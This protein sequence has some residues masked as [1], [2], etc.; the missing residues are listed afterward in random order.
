[1]SIDCVNMYQICRINAGIKSREKASE[2]LG[3]GK[4]SLDDYEAGVT[5]PSDETVNKMAEVYSDSKL[6]YKHQRY[7]TKAGRKTLPEIHEV[8]VIQLTAML[9]RDVIQLHNLLDSLLEIVSDGIIS[10]DEL[11]IWE[12]GKA[13]SF[14][15]AGTCLSI[16]LM[17]L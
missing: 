3:I 1:M 17:T 13:K 5:I 8:N 4:R 12:K 10:D 14:Q 9:H 7:S 16:A 11:H 15:L 6:L 2:L